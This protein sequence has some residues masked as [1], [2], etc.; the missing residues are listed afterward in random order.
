MLTVYSTGMQVIGEMHENKV[1]TMQQEIDEVRNSIKS[2]EAKILELMQRRDREAKTVQAGRKRS[3]HLKTVVKRATAHRDL[4]SSLLQEKEEL[5]TS[6]RQEIK[7]VGPAIVEKS[8]SDFK[9]HAI[10]AS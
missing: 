8:T 2:K 5:M 9:D 7:K 6:L 4:K 3:E 10:L 1:A